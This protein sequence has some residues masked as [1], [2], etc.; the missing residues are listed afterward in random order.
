MLI[1]QCPRVPDGPSPYSEVA[2]L[3]QVHQPA[4]LEATGQWSL[5]IHTR[6]DGW[7]L[8]G[9]VKLTCFGVNPYL[10]IGLVDGVVE[11]EFN[12][13]NDLQSLPP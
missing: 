4:A 8:I 13:I 1:F 5:P 10:T 9:R 3:L 11:L 7:G 12:E 6:S 2:L